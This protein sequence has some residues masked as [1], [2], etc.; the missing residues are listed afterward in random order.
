ML[1]VPGGL[2]SDC[3]RSR[4]G[5]SVHVILQAFISLS[6]LL[7]AQGCFPLDNAE[8]PIDPLLVDNDGDGFAEEDGSSVAGGD[9]DDTNP[10]V[11]PGAFEVCD[12]LDNDCNGSID[13]G[14][15]QDEDGYLDDYA[16]ADFAEELD[17]DDDDYQVN[18]GQIE[19]CDQK[20]N[21]CDGDVDEGFDADGDG[22]ASCVEIDAGCDDLEADVYPG[23]KESCDGLDN[24]CDGR[25]D[26]NFQAENGTSLCVDDDLDGYTEQEGDC[27]DTDRDISPG[28]TEVCN[29]KDDNCDGVVNEGFDQD[30][31]GYATCDGDCDDSDPNV[32][33]G[34]AEVCDGIDNNCHGGADE[35]FQ[36]DTDGD[37]TIDCMD[38][39]PEDPASFPGAIE[40]CDGVD[41]D[42]DTEVDEGFDQDG[43]G[44]G[45]CEG[46]DC[47][48]TDP[49]IYPGADEACDGI[50][51]DCDTE[52]DEGFDQDGDG[53]S[54]CDTSP[55]CDDTDPTVYPGATEI[56]SDG[57]DNDCNGQVDEPVDSD[58]DGETTCDGD[59]DDTDPA[60][61]TGATE[62]CDGV[63]NDCDGGVD[64]DFDLDGDGYSTCDDRGVDCDD[65]DPNV[66]PGAAEDCSDLVDNNCNGEIDEDLDQDLDGV[67]TCS[68]DCD[69]TN[70]SVHPG[71]VEICN[72]R[73]DDCSGG[74]GDFYVSVDTEGAPGA[75]FNSIQDA[76]DSDRVQDGCSVEVAPG[77]YYELINYHGKLINL[78]SEMGPEVTIIDGQSVGTVVTFESAEGASAV[79]D[80][81]T[82]TGGVGALALINC[83]PAPCEKLFF[84]AGV[85]V[86]DSSAP[87]I[88]NNI[89]YDNATFYGGGV[90]SY[91]S[92]PTIEG[93]EFIE[94][95]GDG[96]AGIGAL[97]GAP[98]VR[99]N[100]FS[101]NIG[102]YMASAIYFDTVT[103]GVIENNVVEDNTMDDLVTFDS[104]QGTIQLQD[105]VG[106]V[107]SGNTITGNR[108]TVAAGIA[109]G[110][111]VDTV[112]E[113][114]VLEDNVATYLGGGIIS[115][116]G[117]GTEIRNNILRRNIAPAG[118]G[119]LYC[120]G[121][122]G[123]VNLTITGNTFEANDG[124]SFGGAAA[125]NSDCVATVVQNVFTRNQAL[126]GRGGGVDVVESEAV[127]ENNVFSGNKAINGGGAA[128][129][130]VA[131][132]AFWNNTF[133]GNSA[134]T[135]GG[136][137]YFVDASPL[138]VNNLVTFSLSGSGL[139][140]AEDQA[141]PSMENFRYNDF[142]GNPS[143]ETN[144][145]GLVLINA[146][147][148]RDPLYVDRFSG[149][150]HLET[151][152]PAIDAG[153][154]EVGTDPDGSPPDMGAYGGPLG[155]W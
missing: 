78:R 39:A 67:S 79:L 99:D 3:V 58:Q 16:C 41:N 6:L 128:V 139:Y 20:D 122:D 49:A 137:V 149:D 60:I 8:L 18:P 85:D 29:D 107:V 35:I 50:D 89:F 111:N 9:C 135:Y 52:V 118:G 32:N 121:N 110:N 77:T 23:A 90:Y 143:G 148:S 21:D 66:N 120:D 102:S 51:N 146:N 55:D 54:L 131:V 134:S 24:D 47:D 65:S 81:F 34:A 126:D 70:P 59:C 38:C 14:F 33:P 30:G 108:A 25:V 72:D 142:Y 56:C 150:F 2:L 46:Q 113:D 136:G 86:R 1:K 97:E 17:C 57:R 138:F 153:S 15:D 114:N 104:G 147:M 151:G 155:L 76:I 74:S 62:L 127:F 100:R 96:G 87:T 80:G 112:V 91:Q 101:G 68:G 42:C 106:V 7:F 141:A 124:G 119:G 109:L 83:V 129:M 64:E 27:D 132:P 43:D 105:C 61:H 145:E 115:Y 98:I 10:A 4:T 63:D 36:T 103:G 71:A 26:E 116:R 45:G 69:D 125:F 31:D 82:I 140:Y 154:T 5:R 88:R 13:E 44:F 19:L 123:M 28:A 22:Y 133:N 75:D 94:N 40:I 48:D 73:D 144:L 11:Y 37:G 152:S 93:N 12:G 53:F 130:G 117:D 92:S 84:G 95:T